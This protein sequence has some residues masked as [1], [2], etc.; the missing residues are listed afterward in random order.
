[1]HQHAPSSTCKHYF[2][3]IY[4]LGGKPI[5]I[6][7][8]IPF[9]DNN[10]IIKQSLCQKDHVSFYSPLVI[11]TWLIKVFFLKGL[12]GTSNSTLLFYFV[13]DF[14]SHTILRY[15]LAFVFFVNIF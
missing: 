1:M 15:F 3:F 10:K 2:L 6:Y 5:N 8:T 14:V 13:F 4:F 7:L 9:K 12:L 11:A